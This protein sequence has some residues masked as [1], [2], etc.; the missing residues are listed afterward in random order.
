M[1]YVLPRRVA[2]LCDLTTMSTSISISV[3]TSIPSPPRSTRPLAA[4][5]QPNDLAWFST[6]STSVTSAKRQAGGER[7]EGEHRNKRKRVE[8][9]LQT[10]SQL[11]HRADRTHERQNEESPVVSV[12]LLPCL[13]CG[14]H[15]GEQSRPITICQ[16]TRGINLCRIIHDCDRWIFQ[17]SRPKPCTGISFNTTSFLRCTHHRSACMIRL[18]RPRCWDPYRV[19]LAG[20]VHLP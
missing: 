5:K 6:G 9:T 1:D 8:P 17:L 13:R 16:P 10:T 11:G 12:V 15:S 14:V 4:R 18:R 2:R 19:P 3:P 20:R 7:V